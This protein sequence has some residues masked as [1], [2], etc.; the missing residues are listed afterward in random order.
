LAGS[1]LLVTG[2]AGAVGNAAIH[3]ARWADATV[4]ATVSSD[5]K[6]IFAKAAGADHVVNYRAENVAQRV[7]SIVP[8]GVDVVVEV[9]GAA[10]AETD[11]AILAPHG[12]VACYAGVVEDRVVLPIRS[13]ID[14]NVSWHGVFLY[15][16]PESATVSGVAA[17]SSAVAEGALRVG[18]E[19]GLPVVRFPLTQLAE[20]HAA[21]SA[22]D[23]VGKALI[24]VSDND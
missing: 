14:P 9:A 21:V 12:V 3:L 8:N 10:N 17:V 22:G 16:I 5:R 11:I 13:L 7:R 18:T 24:D 15:T 6:A 4:I 19:A 23:I 1:T 2:G 20:A